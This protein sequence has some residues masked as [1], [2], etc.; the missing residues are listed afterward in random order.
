MSTRWSEKL[1]AHY[2][3]RLTPDLRAWIDDDIWRQAGGA[4]FSQPQTPDHLIEPNGAIW[5][6][7]MLPDTLPIIG[8][9]YGDWLCLRVDA[10]GSLREVVYWCHGGGDWIPYG[11]TLAEALLYDAASRVLYNRKPEFTEPEAPADEVFRLAR[12]ALAFVADGPS[13][14]GNF[15]QGSPAIEALLKQFATASI[16]EVVARR[17]LALAALGNRFRR[18]SNPRLAGTLGIPWEPDFVSWQFDGARV[19]LAQRPRLE[20][21]FQEPF[22]SLA[23]QQWDAAERE[24]LYICRKR[25]DLG[26]AL[27]IAGWAA[28]RRGDLPT[29][30]GLYDAGLAAPVFGDEAV[31]FRSQWFAP[32][33]GKFAAFRLAELQPHLPAAVASNP[34]LRIY[35]ENDEPSLRDRVR[36]HWLALADAAEG[37]RNY[38]EAYQYLYRAGWDLGLPGLEEY[39]SLL[40]RMARI[41]DLASS[42]ALAKLAR[43]HRRSLIGA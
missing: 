35:L 17:D 16:A 1:A 15:W 30:I 31:R 4:E 42:P 32:G 25:Q 39:G 8:N 41:A 34:Y 26:W 40:E 43:A 22:T 12:W 2:G 14:P 29:A 18:E 3:L 19:P 20:Q 10:E 27:D 21:H 38:R 7:F 9:E 37:T 13:S 23:A 6:G 24:A 28:E 11:R 36:D 5:G 33:Y